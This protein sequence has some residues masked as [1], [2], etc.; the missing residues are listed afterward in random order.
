MGKSAHAP[1]PSRRLRRRMLTQSANTH[2]PYLHSSLWPRAR[3][4][5]V[6]LEK[7]VSRGFHPHLDDLLTRL[8]FNH[9]YDKV[10]GA[11]ASF[12]VLA[13]RHGECRPLPP[14]PPS[15]MKES[16]IGWIIGAGDSDRACHKA[17]VCRAPCGC[18]A[19]HTVTRHHHQPLHSNPDPSSQS[20]LLRPLLPA[21]YLNARAGDRPSTSALR[22]ARG[23]REVKR[24]R[25]GIGP[26]RKEAERSIEAVVNKSR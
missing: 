8:N 2:G 10:R 23:A 4:D 18:L 25:C 14:A 7:I 1:Q 22:W 26:W 24:I 12:I 17:S 9:F 5:I 16:E 20:R 19:R 6:V 11:R 15:A 13:A 21:S 3:E